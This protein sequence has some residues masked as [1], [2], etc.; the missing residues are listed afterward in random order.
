MAGLRERSVIDHH[1]TVPTA[2]ERSGDFSKTFAANGNL[3]VIYNPFLGHGSGHARPFP[4]NV[5][6]TSRI[7]PVALN[8][9]KYFP[10]PDQRGQPDHG[11]EQ[12][13]HDRRAQAQY[14]P[15]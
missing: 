6:P 7:D 12:L 3:I 8:M 2:L 1:P 15:V 9:M 4:G 13:L 14:R 5:I 10:A 11:R